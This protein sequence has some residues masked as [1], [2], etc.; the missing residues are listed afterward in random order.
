MIDIISNQ[1][2]VGEDSNE[3]DATVSFIQKIAPELVALINKCI[4]LRYKLP[5]SNKRIER[6]VISTKDDYCYA[7]KGSA[8]DIAEIIYHSVLFYS[9]SEFEI[10]QSDIKDLHE[11]AFEE[12]IRYDET[13]DDDTKQKYGFFGEVFF[14]VFLKLMFGVEAL[15]ARGILYDPTRKSEVTGYDSFHFIQRDGKYELWFGEVK[16]HQ[17]SSGAIESALES[18]IESLSA[19]YLSNNLIL[20]K[21][22]LPPYDESK[23]PDVLKKIL[24]DSVKSKQKIFEEL[25][26]NDIIVVCPIMLIFDEKDIKQKYDEIIKKAVDSINEKINNKFKGKF[27]TK[28]EHT[29]FFIILP[30]EDV[31]KIKKMVLKWISTKESPKLLTQ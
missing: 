13:S 28:I 18:I 17:G 7:N 29:L 2:E 1:S 9:Y 20:L 21:N 3:E 26:K 6:T 12:R 8:E 11:S 30:L 16:F 5:N 31:Q 4:V 10:L 14:D 27:E 22:R 25:K 24:V 19:A 23:L 15:I